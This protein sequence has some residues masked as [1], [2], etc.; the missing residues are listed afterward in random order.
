MN[1]RSRRLQAKSAARPPA[2]AF[3]EAAAHHQAGRLR[4]A[5]QGYGAVLPNQAGYLDAQRRGGLVA[6][7]LAEF[8]LA[9]GFLTRAAGLAPGD[10]GLHYNL[11]LA[12][13]ESGDLA[14]AADCFRRAAD[15]DPADAAAPANLGAALVAQG[16]HRA[17]A[18]AFATSL[19]RQ[20]AHVPVLVNLGLALQGAG[21]DAEAEAAFRQAVALAPDH[22]DARLNLGS[23]LRRRERLDEAIALFRE[24]VADRPEDALALSNLGATLL[25][26]GNHD[27]AAEVCSRL[28]AVTPG[29]AAAHYAL[30]TVLYD[31]GQPDESAAAFRQALDLR[32][33]F[34][35]AWDNLGISLQA[36]GDLVEAIRAHRSAS[37][38]LPQDA[39]CRYNLGTALHAAGRSAEAKMAYEA[40]LHL[41]PDH[42][43]ARHMLS[44]LAGETPETAPTGYVE[45]LFDAYARWF[46]DHLINGLGYRT[47][48]V[49]RDLRDRVAGGG[50]SHGCV[51]DL[52]CGTGLA[53]QVFRDVADRLTGIDLSARMIAE[54]RKK[55]IYDALAIGEAVA[56]LRDDITTYDLVLAADV[57]VYIGTLE[58]LFAAVAAR[59]AGGG[60]FLFSVEYLAEGHFRLGPAGRYAHAEAYIRQLAAGHGFQ[61][62]AAERSELRRDQQQAVDGLVFALRRNTG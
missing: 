6:L 2:P 51:L 4:E 48:G 30:G 50:P 3:V 8:R 57:L 12:F 1:R 43:G 46:D 10:A 27:E 11:G 47:P 28:V 31:V 15:L 22:R 23:A 60:L 5:L 32:P 58:P 24:V 59:M 38:L 61:V 19:Q 49:L 40:C 33:G 13:K 20:P 21:R 53:G 18:E 9:I 55:D 17:A 39:A 7:R 14:R 62:L 45:P 42:A 54:A 37:E 16:N 26:R 34:G 41:A 25:A 35:E 29:D 52:G 44:A 36:L 56:L